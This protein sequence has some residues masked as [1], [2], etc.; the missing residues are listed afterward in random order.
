MGLN[1]M[2]ESQAFLGPYGL[3][4]LISHWKQSHKHENAYKI[5]NLFIIVKDPASTRDMV[6]LKYITECK[7]SSWK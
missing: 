6:K 4:W 7:I 5:I 1:L 2:Q 3:I